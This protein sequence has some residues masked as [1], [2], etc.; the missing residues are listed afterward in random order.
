MAGSSVVGDKIAGLTG[1]QGR[2]PELM[3][4]AGFPASR[5]TGHGRCA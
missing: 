4:L 5:L 3:P 1:P 2:L